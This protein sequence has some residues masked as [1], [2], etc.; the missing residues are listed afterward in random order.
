MSKI[1]FSYEF[2]SVHDNDTVV[3]AAYPHTHKVVSGLPGRNAVSRSFNL[4]DARS[5]G[6]RAHLHSERLLGTACGGDRNVEIG[7][8]IRDDTLSLVLDEL[9]ALNPGLTL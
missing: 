6:G 1:L 3:A 8:V 9:S 4:T 2:L 7:V 5:R